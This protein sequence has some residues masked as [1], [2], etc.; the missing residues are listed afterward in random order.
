VAGLH[1]PTSR[2]I[3]LGTYSVLSVPQVNQGKTAELTGGGG[4]SVGVVEFTRFVQKLAV[5]LHMNAGALAEAM[6]Q[7]AQ[8]A[9]EQLSSLDDSA[10][11]FSLESSD[12][13]AQVHPSPSFRLSSPW[14]CIMP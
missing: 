9:E 7:I 5:L 14:V 12:S 10:I 8:K 6:L 1:Y 13:T 4:R 11:A 3:T 2:A